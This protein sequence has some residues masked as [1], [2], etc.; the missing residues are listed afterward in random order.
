MHLAHMQD[1][2]VGRTERYCK[3]R[4]RSELSRG[5][6]LCGTNGNRFLGFVRLCDE[7]WNQQYEHSA[8]GSMLCSSMKQK[9]QKDRSAIAGN[10]ICHFPIKLRAPNDEMTHNISSLLNSNNILFWILWL[11]KRIPFQS[12]ADDCDH[13]SWQ[14][15]NVSAIY[16]VPRFSAVEM[17]GGSSLTFYQRIH[18]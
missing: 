14:S 5:S 15:S 11:S 4:R 18:T 8:S 16:N 6:E 7:R 13:I 1:A 9:C 17:T 3:T 2:R 10:C 12:K